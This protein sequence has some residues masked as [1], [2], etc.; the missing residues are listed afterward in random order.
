MLL[1]NPFKPD[2]R[3]KKEALTL[4]QAGHRVRIVA[5]DRDCRL[6]EKE[7]LEGVEV[8]RV[9]VRA[10]YGSFLPLVPGFL[11]FYL[12]LLL[13][14]L[15][16]GVDAVHC[17][18]MDTLVPGILI[19]ALRN[20]RVV[21]DMHE[22]YPDFVSTF[23]P[24]FLVRLLRFAEPLLIRRSDLVIVTSSMLG[25]IARQAGA[26]KVLPVMNCYDPFPP[27]GERARDLRRSLLDG[28][29]F[30]VVYVGGLFPGR[31]LEEM[32]RA[33]SG[34]EG[35]RLFLGGYGPLEGELIAMVDGL[36]VQERVI[37]GGEIDPS[38][39]P[40]YDAAAD[41]LFAMYK[42]DD[43][44]NV[45]TIPNKFFESVAA[46]KPILVSDVGEKSLL[47]AEV[48]NGLAVDPSDVG[49]ITGAIRT[50]R[51]DPGTY[52]DMVSAARRSQDIYSWAR[53]AGVLTRAYSDLLA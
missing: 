17:H 51:D 39:V 36:G 50:L 15:K 23:A 18:D 11:L 43:P 20:A 40:D 3:V 10:P 24:G 34:V 22:S 6:P 26:S 9:R 12:R 4:S 46:G 19:G 45:L 7:D 48:G 16:E 14:C 31:G 52:T 53:M 27:G 2:P 49:A 38:L 1:A 13:G 30:L 32:V 8:R 35:V 44:N 47:V 37:L 33:V 29:G 21:Y 41:L 42:A 28:D 25:E 5:W